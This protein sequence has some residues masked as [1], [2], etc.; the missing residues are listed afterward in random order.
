M[1]S[2]VAG[3]IAAILVAIYNIRIGVA[4]LRG[5]RQGPFI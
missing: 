1:S 3:L 2:E 5:S 4:A